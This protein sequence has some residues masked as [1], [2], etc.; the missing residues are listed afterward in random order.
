MSA[1]PLDWMSDLVA[2]TWRLHD[3][4]R[5]ASEGAAWAV[6]SSA[7]LIAID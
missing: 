6:R 1:A 2:G 5:S 4:G 3:W 7:V